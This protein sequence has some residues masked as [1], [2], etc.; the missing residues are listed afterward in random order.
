MRFMYL[1]QYIEEM[2]KLRDAK[3]EILMEIDFYN[4]TDPSGNT[5]VCWVIRSELDS[6]FVVLEGA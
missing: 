3:G 4:K 5:E 1:S 2:G 6:P